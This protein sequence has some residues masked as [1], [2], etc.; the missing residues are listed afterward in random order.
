MPNS[1]LS[2]EHLLIRP[3]PPYEPPIRR[4]RRQPICANQL[5]LP[6]TLRTTTNTS[7]P[8]PTVAGE[9]APRPP[10]PRELA[11]LL[12]ALIE[13][14][15]GRRALPKMR[16]LLDEQAYS[17]IRDGCAAERA[18]GYTVKSVHPCFPNSHVLEVCATAVHR[19]RHRAIAI[20]ARLEAQQSRWRF[21]DF[22]VINPPQRNHSR[23][24]AAA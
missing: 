11:A 24:L 16:S 19:R 23:Q 15:T 2:T 21:T 13:V 12:T 9:P 8:L 10:T 18:E 3:L 17:N 20:V 22:S 7:S 1:A 4:H 5:S 14:T 6:L